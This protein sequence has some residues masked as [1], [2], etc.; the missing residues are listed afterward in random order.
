[1]SKERRPQ[2]ALPRGLRLIGRFKHVGWS[3]HF[4]LLVRHPS[5]PIHAQLT[6][7]LERGLLD[8]VIA[9][10]GQIN[11][12]GGCPVSRWSLQPSPACPGFCRHES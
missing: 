5:V 8:H 9:T 1:M 12:M 2:L 10:G 7:H 4:Q 6:G 3:T 11:I